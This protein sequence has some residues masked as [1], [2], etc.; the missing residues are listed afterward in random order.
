MTHPSRS[1]LPS[2]D[3]INTGI[4]ATVLRGRTTATTTKEPFSDETGQD[5]LFRLTKFALGEALR[6][7]HIA[8]G[9]PG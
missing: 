3:E 7:Q 1:Q 9:R 8:A 2:I 6:W 5:Y 4:V